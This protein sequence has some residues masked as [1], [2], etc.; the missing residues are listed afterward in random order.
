MLYEAYRAAGFDP[1][2]MPIASLTTSEAEVAEMHAEAA[3]GHITAAPFFETLF[4][5]V[6]AAF[7]R[8]AS[9]KNTAPTRR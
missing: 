1:T 6:R 5:A 8:A 4:I 7:R 3:E 2:K 9:R